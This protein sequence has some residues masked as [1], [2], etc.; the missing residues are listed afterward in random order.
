VALARLRAQRILPRSED[1]AVLRLLRS[2]AGRAGRV[3]VEAGGAGG[4]L[5]LG[6]IEG[7]EPSEFADGQIE[8]R[9][10]SPMVLLTFAACL[11]TCWPDPD[12]DPYPGMAT[13]E[14]ALLATLAALGRPGALPLEDGIGGGAERHHKSALRM[15][16]AAGLLAADN[17]CVR[18]GPAVALWSAS[19]VAALRRFHDRLPAPSAVGARA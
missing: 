15:L 1:P 7:S 17:S 19:D 18:L 2:A 3:L 6:W 9:R 5:L 11:R 12:T 16:R 4:G 10:P 14:S 13:S 8:R